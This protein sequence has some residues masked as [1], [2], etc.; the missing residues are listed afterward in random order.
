M[1]LYIHERDWLKINGSM[2]NSILTPYRQLANVPDTSALDF[3]YTR[4]FE[5]I[6]NTLT[7]IF[8]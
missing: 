2:S 8:T 5:Q 1:S 4:Q 6:K 3:N 7:L